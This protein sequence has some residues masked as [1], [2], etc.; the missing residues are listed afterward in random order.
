MAPFKPVS[1]EIINGRVPFGT[2]AAL[3]ICVQVKIYIEASEANKFSPQIL[4]KTM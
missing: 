4:G 2:Q 3:F 1:H